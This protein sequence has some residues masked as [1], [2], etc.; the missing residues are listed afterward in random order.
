[1]DTVHQFGKLSGKG[2]NPRNSKPKPGQAVN[3][4][5]KE[6]VTKRAK[7]MQRKKAEETNKQTGQHTHIPSWP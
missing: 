1:M 3:G 2:I 5:R 6:T 4:K 7:F